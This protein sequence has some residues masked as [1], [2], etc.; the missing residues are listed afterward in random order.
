MIILS[1]IY[2]ASIVLESFLFCHPVAYN[3][4]KSINGTSKDPSLGYLLAAIT[5][6]LIDVII[7]FLPLSLL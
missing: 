5:N 6:L 1:L 2:F 3:W 7:V 4:D